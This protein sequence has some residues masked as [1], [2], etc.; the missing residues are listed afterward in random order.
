MPGALKRKR[1]HL[2]DVQNVRHTVIRWHILGRTHRLARSSAT[3]LKCIIDAC[4]ITWL[5]SLLGKIETH[6][7]CHCDHWD[8]IRKVFEDRKQE[9]L[10]GMV[11]DKPIERL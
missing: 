3:S 10:C 2:I 5:S 7:Q 1:L 9:L 6:W 4:A 8:E 11:R